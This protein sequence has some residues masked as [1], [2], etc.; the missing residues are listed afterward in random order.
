MKITNITVVSIAALAS[1]KAESA[2]YCLYAPNQSCYAEGWPS[3]CVS[4]TTDCPDE[5]PQCELVGSSYC[6]W[7]ENGSN[8]RGYNF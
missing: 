1:E 5:Q 2:P 7:Y 8:Q 6:T 3:C 4:N